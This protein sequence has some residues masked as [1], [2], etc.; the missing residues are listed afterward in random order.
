M[1]VLPPEADINRHP[2]RVR[3]VPGTDIM[4]FD[5]VVG[6]GVGGWDR[7]AEGRGGPEVHAELGER[8]LLG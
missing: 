5:H 4:L 6:A 7:Q 3:K 8:R 1:W 2:R